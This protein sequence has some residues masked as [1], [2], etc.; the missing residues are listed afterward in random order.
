MLSPETFLDAAVSHPG[1]VQWWEQGEKHGGELP[2]QCCRRTVP[3]CRGS[4]LPDTPFP[5]P[6]PW[7]QPSRHPQG[8]TASLRHLFGKGLFHREPRGRAGTERGAEEPQWEDRAKG[9]LLS[10]LFKIPQ[11]L[12][13]SGER[14][15]WGMGRGEQGMG[16]GACPSEGH[17]EDCLT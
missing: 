12:G 2:A 9:L 7:P 3:R 8:K 6:Q 16:C 1:N 14:M 4:S 10:F 11:R 17:L 15:A 13:G 5:L